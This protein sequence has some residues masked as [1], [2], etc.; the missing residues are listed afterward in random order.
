MYNVKTYPVT[1]LYVQMWCNCNADF[2]N[3]LIKSSGCLFN[4]PECVQCNISPLLFLYIDFS[5]FLLREK[6]FLLVKI[7]PDSYPHSLFFSLSLSFTFQKWRRSLEVF[8]GASMTSKVMSPFS[9]SLSAESAFLLIVSDISMVW[10]KLDRGHA[11]FHFL[12]LFH[13]LISCACWGLHSWPVREAF[14]H[15]FLTLN[16]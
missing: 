7:R 14:S 1:A 3:V 15:F 8:E 13:F 5:L 4:A 9:H 2:A 12:P 16:T 11:E 10:C 6:A